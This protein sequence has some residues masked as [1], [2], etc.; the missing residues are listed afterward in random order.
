MKLIVD[1]PNSLYANLAKIDNGS[2]ASKRII[3]CVKHGKPYK[4]DVLDKI[5]A[6]IANMPKLY[7]FID[8]IDTYVKEDDVLAIID[9]YR[10]EQTDAT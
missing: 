8:H 10:K 6:E 7:P 3:E 4:I 1:I 5:R 2:I 9:R